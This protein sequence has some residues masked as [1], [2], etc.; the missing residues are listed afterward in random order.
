MPANISI[1]PLSYFSQTAKAH[2]IEGAAFGAALG[3]IN[4]IISVRESQLQD[5]YDVATEALTHV[6][7]GA[8]LGALAATT[9]G[10]AG[11]S[12]AGVAGRGITA[13]VVPLVVSSVASGSAHRPVERLVRSWSEDVVSGLRRTLERQASSKVT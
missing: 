7:T 9:A 1:R 11:V 4:G 3:I 10:L 13:I 12:V 2:A 8:V 6:G 5:R